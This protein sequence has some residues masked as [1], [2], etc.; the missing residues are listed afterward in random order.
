MYFES[1]KG[2]LMIRFMIKTPIRAAMLSTAYKLTAQISRPD[3]RSV[4]KC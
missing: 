2:D 1:Q 4:L 3:Q